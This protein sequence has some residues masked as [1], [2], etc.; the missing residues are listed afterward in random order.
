MTAPRLTIVLSLKGRALFTLRFLWHADRARLPYRFLIAD[1][2]VHPR[3]AEML[4][5]ARAIFPN[6]DIEYIR[7]PD[8]RDFG[9]WFRKVADALSRVQTP[10]AVFADNDDFLVKS[11]IERSMDFLDVHRDYVCC[12][13]GLGGFSVYSGLYDPL[14]GLIGRL[15]KYTYRYTHLDRSEDYSSSS[16]VE[17]LRQGSRNWWSHY[18][19]FRTEALRTIANEIVEIN[20]SD[21]QLH[22][23]FCA[24]RTL[25]LG[26]ARSDPTTMGYLRQY[27]TSMQS[28]FSKDRDWIH[29]IVRSRFNS[30][31]AAMIAKLSA[32][33]AAADQIDA[34]PVA[35]MLRAICE[36]FLREFLQ[37]S[38][39]APQKM[40][41]WIR[42]RVPQL[43]VWLKKHRRPFAGRERS[44]IFAQL[45]SD[46]ATAAYLAEFEHELTLIEEVIAGQGF[47]AFVRPYVTILGTR[48]ALPAAAD[49]AL[50]AAE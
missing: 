8:D 33:A 22:E 21:L 30:D 31:Y 28:A 50:A 15:N 24:M 2:E 17:R 16:A 43:V 38:Y 39:G 27:G 25:T 11:G 46:G 1:G 47:A 23:L 10:Y 45:T 41:K 34:A 13:G 35:E 3:L 42:D 48:G 40:K 32:A 19:V 12:G 18:A 44:K 7:Y 49:Q 26:K 4:E 29:H 37:A 5:N 14:N 6:L 20:F 36:R 9:D